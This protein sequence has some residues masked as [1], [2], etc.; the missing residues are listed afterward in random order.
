MKRLI[1]VVVLAVSL[2]LILNNVVYAGDEGW[3]AAGGLL[4]GLILGAALSDHHHHY[5]EPVY[6]YEPCYTPAPV[7]YTPVYRYDTYTT[8]SYCTSSFGRTTVYEH[9][10]VHVW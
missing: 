5:A 3:Y 8:Y 1:L 9:D 6:V 2:S 10:I 4:G 7:V